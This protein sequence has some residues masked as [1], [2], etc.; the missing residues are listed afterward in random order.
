MAKVEAVNYRKK[1]QNNNSQSSLSHLLVAVIFYELDLFLL[2]QQ[3][4]QSHPQMHHFYTFFRNRIK[5]TAKPH[6]YS[7]GNEPNTKTNWLKI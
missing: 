4:A 7:C 3:E 2:F 5:S 6:K 1:V